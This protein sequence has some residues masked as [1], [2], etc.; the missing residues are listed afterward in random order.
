[1]QRLYCC[2]QNDLDLHLVRPEGTAGDYGSCPAECTV[3]TTPDGG[4]PTTEN[5]C[6][7]DAELYVDSCRHEGSDCSFANRYPEWF[8]AGRDDDPRLDLDDVRGFG[9]EVITLNE[10]QD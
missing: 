3:T 2:G 8:E 6:Y 1:N 4:L 7:E 10:A 9:P 5:R